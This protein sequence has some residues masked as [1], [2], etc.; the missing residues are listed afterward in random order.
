MSRLLALA[1][2]AL[3]ALAVP[4]AAGSVVFEASAKDSSIRLTCGPSATRCT[5][6]EADLLIKEKDKENRA[7]GKL[8]PDLNFGLLEFEGKD[9]KRGDPETVGGDFAITA[10]LAFNILGV[11]KPFQ[12]VAKGNGRYLVDDD[13]IEFLTLAW[14]PIENLIVKGVGTFAFAFTEITAPQL[15]ARQSND[16]DDSNA[17]D[18]DQPLVVRATVT[19][20]SVVPLP[21]GGVLLLTAFGL[22]ALSARQRR[23]ALAA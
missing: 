10:T 5:R 9:G 2:S 18:E 13:D 22:L 12:I 15:F 4:A 8:A 6:L 14:Q 11:T 19:D 20:V 21:A 16:T 17:D 1:G 23:R 7:A 3:L